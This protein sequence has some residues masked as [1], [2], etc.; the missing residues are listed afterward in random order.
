MTMNEA[1]RPAINCYDKITLNADGSPDLYFGPKAPAGL[2]SNRVEQAARPC[3]SRSR[4]TR[5]KRIRRSRS[6][7]K[8]P[9]AG[10]HAGRRQMDGA[11]NFPGQPDPEDRQTTNQHPDRWQ[12]LRRFPLVTDRIGDCVSMS[13]SSIPRPNS[14]PNRTPVRTNQ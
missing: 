8:R 1:D 5:P 7:R 10:T 13:R 3:A 14:T 12:V 2:E 9:E 11:A 4:P 6:A